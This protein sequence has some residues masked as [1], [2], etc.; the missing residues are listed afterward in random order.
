MVSKGE[1]SNFWRYAWDYENRL[2]TASTRKQKVRNIYDVLGDEFITSLAA[3]KKLRNPFITAW[4][5][6]FEG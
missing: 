2:T 3:A 4:I 1:S 6:R 5:F